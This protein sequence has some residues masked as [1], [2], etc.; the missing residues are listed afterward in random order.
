MGITSYFFDTYAFCEIIVGNPNYQKY[1]NKLGIITTR[2]NLMELYYGL[3][4]ECD[5]KTADKYYD[6]LIK[7]VINIDDETIKQ[8]MVFRY[9]NKNK[10]LSY[11]DCIGYILAKKMG[12]K[13]LTGDKEFESMENVEFVK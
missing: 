11:V 5:R 9:L 10:K 12:L 1:V 13:F 6:S 7:Y 3:L 4:R 8:A 2:L